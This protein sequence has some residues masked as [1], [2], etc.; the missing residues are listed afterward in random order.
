MQMLFGGSVPSSKIKILQNLQDEAR[1]IMERGKNKDNWSHNLF[2]VEQLIKF[3]RLA[4]T[5]K[6]M[7]RTCPESPLDKFP[8]R[9][10]HSNYRTG[11]CKDIQIPRVNIQYVQKGFCYSALPAW[12]SIPISIRELP[13]LPQ[14]R[15][16]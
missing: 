11:N 16:N 14:F 5:Y 10:L 15:R 3:D 7:N 8:Q 12:N 9:S 2:D 4:M 13:T 1:T 6:I